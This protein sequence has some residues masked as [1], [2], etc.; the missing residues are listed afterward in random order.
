M[1]HIPL[2]REDWLITN[3]RLPFKHAAKTA[4][5]RDAKLMLEL[6]RA[7]VVF[8]KC[9]ACGTLGAVPV[10]SGTCTAC[11]AGPMDAVCCEGGYNC[12]DCPRDRT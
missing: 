7:T 6:T 3:V 11:G 5:R 2:T 8:N 4:D 12:T 1:T 9:E 10:D